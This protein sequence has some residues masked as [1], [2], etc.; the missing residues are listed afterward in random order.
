MIFT[1]ALIC[2]F[3]QN[4]PS[5]TMTEEPVSFHVGSVGEIQ[6]QYRILEI[7]LRLSYIY[8]ASLKH[9]IVSVIPWK[10]VNPSSNSLKL[11]PEEF[12]TQGNSWDF[13]LDYDFGLL[14]RNM[15]VY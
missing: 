4:T 9:L 15:G 10:E 14:H 5:I 7:D 12:L 1:I 8:P 2:I 6:Y 3:L 13:C 11:W